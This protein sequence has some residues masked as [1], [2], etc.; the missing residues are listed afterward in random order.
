MEAKVPERL[1]HFEVGQ[2]VRVR[3]VGHHSVEVDV[4][5]KVIRLGPGGAWIN[6]DYRLRGEADCAHPFPPDDEKQRAKHVFA[7]PEDCEAMK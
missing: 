4:P 2:R 5:G 1:A 7:M 3:R 6:L